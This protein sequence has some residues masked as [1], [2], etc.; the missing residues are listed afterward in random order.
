MRSSFGS[1]EISRYPLLPQLVCIVAISN[2]L[3]YL[4]I[5]DSIF[6]IKEWMN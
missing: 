6:F 2:Y 3:I 4:L 5:T 1:I